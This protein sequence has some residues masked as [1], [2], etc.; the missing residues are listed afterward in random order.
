VIRG[1][2]DLLLLRAVRSGS[3]NALEQIIDKYTAY[4][5][6]IVR[7]ALGG[8]VTHEDI[9]ELASDVF[10]AL[11]ENADKMKKANLKA[12]LGA[13]ARNKAKNRLRQVAENLPLDDETIA[14]DGD[15]PE[16]TLIVADE[17]Q[18]VKS[19]IL[20][21]DAPDREIFLRHYYDSQTVSAI[22]EETGITESAVK[23]RLIRGREK[24][25]QIIDREA[26]R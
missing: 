10:F 7:G 18:T 8:A 21:M 14:D 6:V 19:A 13:I 2:I 12:Y 17:R 5:C 25:R 20:S 16:D 22:A 3:E 26:L 23:H 24:L 11:W 4:V 1:V 9:E 15:T